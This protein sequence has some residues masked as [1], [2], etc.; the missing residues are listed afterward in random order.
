M[1]EQAK[2]SGVLVLFTLAIFISSCLLFFVQ[3][4]Y[5]KLVLPKL[6]G[7]PSVWATAMLFFQ[8]TLILGYLYAHLSAR[9]LQRSMQVILH[10]ALWMVSLFFLPLLIPEGWTYDAESPAV[11]QTLKLYVLGVGVP[12]LLLAATA[13]LI[14]SWYAG[15]NA[16]LAH[17]PYFLYSASNLGSL[18][19]LMAFPLIAEPFLGVTAITEAWF[20]GFLVQGVVLLVCGL[21]AVGGAPLDRATESDSSLVTVPG[22][23]QILQ[24]VALA[25]VPSSLMLAITTKISLD[26]GAMPLVWVVPLKIYLLTFVLTFT[27]SAR[28]PRRLV[29][30]VFVGATAWLAVVFSGYFFEILD[31][32]RAI[33]LIAAFFGFSIFVHRRLYES[34][35]NKAHITLFYLTLSVGGALGGLLNSIIAPLLFNDLYEGPITLMIGGVF[36]FYIARSS[37]CASNLT[38]WI[39]SHVAPFGV[40]VMSVGCFVA[41]IFYQDSYLYK[42]RSFFGLHTIVDDGDIRKYYNGTT[43]HG[44]QKLSSF[45]HTRPEPLYYY[46]SAGPVGQIMASNIAM[47]AQTVG[48]V[49]LGIG[50][51]ACH[52]K[53]NQ[54]WFFYEIDAQVDKIARNSALFSFISSCTPD[55]PTY[56]GDA[57]TMLTLQ[58][59]KRY[60][61]LMIDAYSSDSVPLHLT[62]REA[63]ELYMQRLSDH[64]ILI[65]HVS[66]RYYDLV[67]PLL[68]SAESLGLVALH[69]DYWEQDDIPDLIDASMDMLMIARKKQDFGA[70]AEDPRWKLL[71]G[72]GGQLWTDEHSSVLSALYR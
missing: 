44:G 18:L 66:N 15:S 47:E 58:S 43:L 53:P 6:G 34:R 48:V 40:L 45:A 61:I 37:K 14:Q 62:T 49:G 68:R 27:N 8:T 4:L 51:M 60:D 20:L 57:R 36:L 70:M 24:W 7:A 72:D 13:P 22:L 63:M 23:S 64:G 31:L 11:V 17:D 30:V 35:P 5:T 32:H 71:E 56:L 21:V 42:S 25:F 12:F 3:P 1:N 52:R 29:H 10:M 69:Q 39:A 38:G 19:A 41:F 46:H 55:A 50:A 54:D 33:L 2:H 28:F 16:H 59:D 9:Y 65:Y 67:P 26:L